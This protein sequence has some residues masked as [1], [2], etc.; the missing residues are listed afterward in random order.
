MDEQL[1]K[2]LFQLFCFTWLTTVFGFEEGLVKLSEGKYFEGGF[3]EIWKD[4]A[5]RGLCDSKK[6]TWDKKAGDVVYGQHGF[7]ESLNSFHGDIQLWTDTGEEVMA[8]Q[9]V[10][11]TG[12]EAS[13]SKCK[14]TPGTQCP[15]QNQVSVLC[16]PELKSVCGR[17]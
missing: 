6:N 16:N 11:C 4:G 17:D 9:G 8:A 14:I 13:L 2:K 12:E 1:S 3:V 7:M 10:E 15:L 5:W